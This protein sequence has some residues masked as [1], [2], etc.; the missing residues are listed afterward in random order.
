M[1]NPNN[2]VIIYE[3]DIEILRA[4]IKW[5]FSNPDNHAIIKEIESILNHAI[6]VD[7]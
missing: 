5:L 1:A 6:I 3:S 2:K 7:N 4:I